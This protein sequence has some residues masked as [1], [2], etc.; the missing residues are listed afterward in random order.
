MRKFQIILKNEAFLGKNF[1]NLMSE[2]Q[3]EDEKLLKPDLRAFKA[4]FESS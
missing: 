4:Q 1:K 3:F 2:R